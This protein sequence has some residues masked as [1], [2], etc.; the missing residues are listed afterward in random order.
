[1]SRASD[2]IA[3]TVFIRSAVALFTWPAASAEACS[4]RLACVTMRALVA[5]CSSTAAAI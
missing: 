2:S 1:M 4:V 3:V 5:F